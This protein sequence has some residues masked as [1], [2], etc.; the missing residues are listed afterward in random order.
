MND[1]P[2]KMDLTGKM[3]GQLYVRKYAGKAEPDG[4]SIWECRCYRCFRVV[5][6]RA[7]SLVRGQSQTCGCSSVTH[8]LTRGPKGSDK[9]TE[10]KSWI[11]AKD[12]CFNPECPAYADYGGRNITMCAGWKDDYASFYKDLGPKPK[13]KSL[14]RLNNSGNYSCGHCDEC[15]SKGWP[16]NCAWRTQKEQCRNRRSTV[17]ITHDGKTQSMAAWAEEYGI[18]LRKFWDRLMRYKMPIAVALSKGLDMGCKPHDDDAVEAGIGSAGKVEL[19][20]A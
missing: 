12:R 9:P 10:Y 5:T 4:A 2:F 3:F 20:K 7:Q 8:G 1:K 15:K 11:H 6:I 14:D 16:L 19:S 18:D 17:M 13:G